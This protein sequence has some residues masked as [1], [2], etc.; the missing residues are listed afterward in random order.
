METVV[1]LAPSSLTRFKSNLF[2][3]N[4]PG[5]LPATAKD[6]CLTYQLGPVSVVYLPS[7]LTTRGELPSLAVKVKLPFPVFQFADVIFASFAPAIV[8]YLLSKYV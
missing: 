4:P 5:L 1:S 2:V 7:R 3:W 8:I 6:P